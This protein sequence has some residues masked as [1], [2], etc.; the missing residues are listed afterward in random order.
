[1]VDEIN[2]DQKEFFKVNAVQFEFAKVQVSKDA[3]T[4]TKDVRFDFL[5][6]VANVDVPR[7]AKLSVEFPA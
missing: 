6:R 7:D 5:F 4:Y 2:D 1:L 3:K